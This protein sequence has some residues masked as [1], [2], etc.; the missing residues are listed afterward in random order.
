VE[1]LELL[2]WLFDKFGAAALPYTVIAI[3]IWYVFQQRNAAKSAVAPK[4]YQDL[5]NDYQELVHTCHTGLVESVRVTERLAILIE[6]RTR[7]R[8]R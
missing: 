2:N 4:E 8:Q 7:D 6:E 3:L 1:L 5:I